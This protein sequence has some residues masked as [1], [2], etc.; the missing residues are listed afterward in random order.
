MKKAPKTRAAEPPSSSPGSSKS[1]VPQT[2]QPVVT[3]ALMMQQISNLSKSV[4]TQNSTLMDLPRALQA[5]TETFREMTS[6]LKNLHSPGEKEKLTDVQVADEPKDPSTDLITAAGDLLDNSMNTSTSVMEDTDEVSEAVRCILAQTMPQTDYGENL[7]D[8]VASSFS[9]IANP[10]PAGLLEDMKAKFK[11]PGNCKELGVAKVNP[12]I[13]AGLPQNVKNKDAKSQHLQQHLSRALVAQART[14][15]QVMSLLQKTKLPELQPILKSLMDSAMS[16]GQAVN[17]VNVS[18]KYTLKPSLLPEYSGL[19][20]AGLP[21]TEFLFGDN[22]ESS[23]KLLKS[24]SKIVKPA[25]V[26]RYHPYQRQQF[27]SSPHSANHLNF[28]RQ[29]FRPPRQM[30]GTPMRSQWRPNHQ[31]QANKKFRGQPRQ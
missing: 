14:A 1:T 12:E 20:S 16:V 25:S 10:L 19:A 3:G 8:V 9:K 11:V 21:V 31:F 23:L 27:R 26:T 2:G 24:T 6:M 7:K 13:W 15:E 29:S 22:L 5:Q 18:R 17:E 28:Q 30:T 4:A